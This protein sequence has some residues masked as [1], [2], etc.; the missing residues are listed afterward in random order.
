MEER[1]VEVTTKFATT[2]DDLTAAWAFV[3]DHIDQLGPDPSIAINPFW[4]II[5]GAEQGRRFEVVVSG[6]VEHKAAGGG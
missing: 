2:V 6:M 1:T 5:D 4:T 3:M